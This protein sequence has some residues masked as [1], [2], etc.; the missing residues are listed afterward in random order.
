MQGTY[1]TSSMCPLGWHSQQCFARSREN[2]PDAGPCHTSTVPG[3]APV[4]EGRRE[5]PQGKR[6]QRAHSAPA[7]TLAGSA[8]KALL[9]L[10]GGFAL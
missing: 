1:P 5:K 7:S 10:E 2:L 8:L 6:A 4:G 3:Q 9:G